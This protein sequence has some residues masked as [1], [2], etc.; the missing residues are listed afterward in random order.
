M[1]L[2][3]LKGKKTPFTYCLYRLKQG[4]NLQSNLLVTSASLPSLVILYLRVTNQ[5]ILCGGKDIVLFRDIV[6]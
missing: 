1:R 3:E 4:L 6:T 2:I 5:R